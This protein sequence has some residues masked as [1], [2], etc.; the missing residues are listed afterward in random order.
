MLHE[1]RQV[2]ACFEFVVKTMARCGESSYE[3]L[4]V[5]R[6][7]ELQGVAEYLFAV[8]YQDDC[9]VDTDKISQ[10]YQ[11]STSGF[12]AVGVRYSQNLQRS[13]VFEDVVR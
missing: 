7:N 10:N 11:R 9:T 13:E 6:P 8:S 1:A 5:G 3:G 12:R 2:A 4:L